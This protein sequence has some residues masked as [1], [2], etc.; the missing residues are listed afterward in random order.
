MDTDYGSSGPSGEEDAGRA[1]QA[2]Q[3]SA[4]GMP[5]SA[6]AS[7][8][9]A[10][11]AAAR[12][13]AGAAQGSPPS[14]GAPA[15]PPP[16]PPP[17]PAWAG[18]KG[19]G[20]A[21]AQG[22]SPEDQGHGPGYEA[23]PGYPAGAPG[24]GPGGQGYPAGGH[25]YAPGGQGYPP[26]GP[27]YGPG[28]PGYYPGGPGYPGGPEHGPA[29][30][31]GL[32]GPGRPGKSR[33][34]RGLA[35]A[36][37]GTALALVAGGSAWAAI[38]SADAPLSTAAIASKTDPGLVDI[39][40]TI[41]YGQA[42]A[43]GTGMVLTSNGEVLT[44]NH[45]IE[46]ATSIKVRDI[47]NGQT[48]TAKVVGYSDTDDVAVLQLQGASGLA[49]VSIGSSSGVTTGQRIV[50]LGNAEG[51]GGT[52]AVATGSV[53]A[54]GAAITAEDE[55]DGTLEHLN[56]MIQTNAP[57][58]PGDSGGPVLN[59]SGQVVGMDTA[60]STANGQTGTTADVTTTAFAIPIS[61]AISIADQIEAGATSSAVHVG[62]TAFLG[63]AVST[64]SGQQG[65]GQASTGAPIEG[66][67]KNTPAAEIGLASG[68]TITA[69]DGHDVAAASDL[70][71]LIQ[72]YRPGERISVT[73]TDPSGQSHTASVTLVA[74]PA[75]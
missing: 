61:R 54:L 60:A 10:S 69:I 50:A 49:T 7:G 73:W 17:H 47:G 35:L 62:E 14:V 59:A 43:A 58:E 24:Y 41:D 22:Y 68:D 52:P 45:V 63:V 55:G 40:T 21:A 30:P 13:S 28:G 1:S 36:A 37:A 8:A 32:D 64:Q 2:G 53:T 65:F 51:R 31:A 6:S 44:N 70:Q 75:G 4:P 34:R 48:Y 72:R 57:I 23:G 20:W 9:S 5:G 39:N 46:G 12:P 38:G 11:G 27:G 33:K 16:P 25:G 56:N 71:G 42:A 3:G 74:G 18:P 29:F 15:A 66:V 67:I 19:G 26:G